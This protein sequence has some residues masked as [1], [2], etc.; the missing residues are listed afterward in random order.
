MIS[1]SMLTNPLVMACAKFGSESFRFDG[2]P[3]DFGVGP[4]LSLLRSAF[5]RAFPV[6]ARGTQ[7]RFVEHQ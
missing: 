6:A 1:W 3:F 4:L 7:P 2:F 5:A